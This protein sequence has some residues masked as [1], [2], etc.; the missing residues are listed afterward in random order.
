M[1]KRGREGLTERRAAASTHPHSVRWIR[2]RVS[3]MPSRCALDGCGKP[4]ALQASLPGDVAPQKWRYYCSM[5]HLETAGAIQTEANK[6]QRAASLKKTQNRG[7]RTTA[8]PQLSSS[9]LRLQLSRSSAQKRCTGAN[10]WVGPCVP[11][12]HTYA[13]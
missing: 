5:P 2:T 13:A 11:P 9:C 8:H 3:L 4:A 7:I 10:V 12:V 6:K 1:D